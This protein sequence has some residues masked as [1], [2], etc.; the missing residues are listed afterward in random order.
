MR[1]HIITVPFLAVST[2]FAAA[3]DKTKTEREY[4]VRRCTPK[5]I[6]RDSNHSALQLHKG[7]KYRHSPLVAFEILESGETANAILKRSSGIAEVDKYALKSVQE[8]KFNKRP[9]C[10]VIETQLDVTIHFR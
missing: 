5:L 7:E 4:D 10:G 2:A 8:S 6:S 1:P 3:Q 9:G